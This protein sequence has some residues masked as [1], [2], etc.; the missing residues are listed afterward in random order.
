MKKKYICLVLAGLITVTTAGIGMNMD[1][2]SFAATKTKPSGMPLTVYTQDT[3]TTETDTADAADKTGDEGVKEEAGDADSGLSAADKLGQT[4]AITATKKLS[5]AEAIKVMQTTGT[6]A[7]TAKLHRE[8]DIAVGNGYAEKVQKINKTERSLDDLDALSA[9]YSRLIAMG[10]TKEQA[11][12]YLQTTKG[13][14]NASLKVEK[15]VELAYE[16]QQAGATSNNKKI[17][18]LRREFA[19]AN[20]ENNYQAEMNQIEVDTINVYD[21]VILAQENLRIAKENQV[22]TEKTLKNVEAKKAVGL[23]SKKDVLQ[24]KSAVADAKSNVRTA[25][26]QLK[27][28]KM[29]FNYL[30]GYNVKQEVTLTDTISTLA[31]KEGPAD[32]ETAIAN[33]MKN[34]L[35]LKGANL[36][37]QIYEILLQDVSAYPKTSSTYLNAK[38]Q[39]AEG[40][41][42]ARDA[43]SKIE[44]DIRNKYNQVMDA[45]AELDAAQEL[46]NYAAEGERLMQL[47]YTEGIS[48]VDELLGVQV[49]HYQAKLNLANCKLQYATALKSYE[50]AQGVG[51][52]R[53]PL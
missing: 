17:L 43:Y 41:Q 47:T 37:V 28:A 23:V 2:A 39:L 4:P 44:I 7:E 3:K 8:S 32:P 50:Y 40:E 11:N 15:A 49:K 25:E 30:L 9:G 21:K 53:L 22:A 18:Q 46:L 38:I 34:R 26:T 33:A 31:T 36:A 6:S 5:L 42:T 10:M 13:V 14:S 27:Y 48:T 29:S 12:A 35:E 51:A 45:K 16:A 19:R 52:T 20:T 24:A 1:V